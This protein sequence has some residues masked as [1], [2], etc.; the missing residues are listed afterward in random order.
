M[1][2]TL[3]FS[4]LALSVNRAP[5]VTVTEGAEPV[6]L[7][8]GEAVELPI[9]LSDPDGDQMT[10]Y[11][12]FDDDTEWGQLPMS[13]RPNVV[14][15]ALFA[16]LDRNADHTMHLYA[17]DGQVE[18][19][20]VSV[21]LGGG[22]K[23]RPWIR[24]R[25]PKETARMLAELRALRTEGKH[26]PIT[27]LDKL[28]GPQK[29]PEQQP[30]EQQPTEQQPSEEQSQDIGIPSVIQSLTSNSV[31]V[32]YSFDD[33]GVWSKPVSY[34]LGEM[35]VLIPYRDFLQHGA[36]GTHKVTLRFAEEGDT[37]GEDSLK[38]SINKEPV[39]QATGTDTL[40]FKGVPTG[41]V[42][43][44]LSVMDDDGDEVT[45]WYRFD[46]QGDW[47]YVPAGLG[48]NMLPAEA[49]AGREAGS[50]GYVE[51]CAYDGYE[52]SAERLRIG[53]SIERDAE[54]DD[55]LF[56]IL[57]PAAFAGIIIG[58]VAMIALTIAVIVVATRKKPESSSTGLIES[59]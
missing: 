58:G 14:P 44:P 18:S 47:T 41:P 27:P 38:Y 53:Y 17:S 28:L 42:T 54:E 57:S 9:H 52:H 43:L 24:R 51:V 37:V 59:E 21:D 56:G 8:Y 13:D 1:W 26:A 23:R 39:I 33:S 12:K 32:P 10:L 6:L 11:Y 7:N 25:S 50:S 22:F 35:E 2:F 15:G 55:A 29:P 20:P 3:V 36:E 49:F 46:G 31:D 5:V 34:P 4:I 45:W 16:H 30:P 48:A 19:P 40:S